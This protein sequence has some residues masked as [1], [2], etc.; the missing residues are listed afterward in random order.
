MAHV[1]NVSLIWWVFI[2]CSQIYWR[3]HQCAKVQNHRCTCFCRLQG[4]YPRNEKYSNQIHQTLSLQENQHWIVI[5]CW[6]SQDDSKS[7]WYI[8][9]NYFN[10]AYFKI[11]LHL[12]CKNDM[13]LFL[14]VQLQIFCIWVVA[15][16]VWNGG[17]EVELSSVLPCPWK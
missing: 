3:M 13:V 6:M 12:P 8:Q 10:H 11:I 2:T 7:N 16:V 1:Y 17:I 9:K 5:L 14:P 4:S 15:C